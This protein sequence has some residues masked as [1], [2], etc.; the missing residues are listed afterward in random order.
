MFFAFVLYVHKVEE[1]NMTAFCARR[2]SVHILDK[3]YCVTETSFL[4]QNA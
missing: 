2:E 3:L 4:V 1:C